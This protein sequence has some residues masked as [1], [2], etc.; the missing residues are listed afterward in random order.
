MRNLLNPKWLFIINTLPIVVL[1]ILFFGQFTIIKSL[2]DENSIQL[3]KSFGL[4]L[5]VLGLLNFAYAFYLT[6]K[7]QNISAGYSIS[8]LLCYITFIYLYGYHLDRIVPFTIPQWMISGNIVIYVGTF[9]MPT[10]AYSL[11]VLVGYFTPENKEH[12]AGINFLIA[13]AVPIAGY[14]FSQI[15]LP[16]FQCVEGRFFVHAILVLVIAATLVFLFL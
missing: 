14:L 5:G 1:F 7:K 4:A 2:L 13:I 8:A 10:L 16:L 12:K 6:I 11:F 3:W 9:L 15:I